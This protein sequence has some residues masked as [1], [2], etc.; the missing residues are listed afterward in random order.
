[1]EPL[2]IRICDTCKYQQTSHLWEISCYECARASKWE[3]KQAMEQGELFKEL[4]EKYEKAKKRT[5]DVCRE[6]DKE[7]RE[8]LEEEIS[9]YKVRWIHA[10]VKP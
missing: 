6:Y 4:L 1:M 2:E 3:P 5:S 10:T 8:E 7:M 9:D